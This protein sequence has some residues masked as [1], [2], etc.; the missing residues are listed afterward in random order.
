MNEKV[1][2]QILAVR[3]SGL[4]NMLDLSMVHRVAR[5]QGYHELV[6]FVEEHPEDYIHFILI[7]QI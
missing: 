6:L 7:G 4:V 3:N 2:N 1:Q 5:D